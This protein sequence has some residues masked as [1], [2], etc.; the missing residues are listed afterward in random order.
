MDDLL[1]QARL[2]LLA[3]HGRDKAEALLRAMPEGIALKPNVACE[4][5]RHPLG[6]RPPGGPRG[7]PPPPV[8]F[9]RGAIREPAQRLLLVGFRMPHNT[10]ALRARLRERGAALLDREMLNDTWLGAEAAALP[11]G[12]RDLAGEIVRRVIVREE[13]PGQLW[14]WWVDR[15][16]I[17]QVDRWKKSSR[18]DH[19]LDPDTQ[20]IVKG[21]LPLPVPIYYAGI[22]GRLDE[23]VLYLPVD[24]T[25]LPRD[26]RV[27]C[28]K[29]RG[30]QRLA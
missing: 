19:P 18:L 26:V 17:V 22:D 27:R 16:G 1:Y 25:M 13:R 14:R 30:V 5:C 4:T 20:I 8:V 23:K 21:V 6:I 29:C 3:A 2:R 12:D 11:E 28:P 15:V 7:E 10:A 24:A 9:V